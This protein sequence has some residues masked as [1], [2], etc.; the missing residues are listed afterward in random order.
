MNV[1][2]TEFRKAKIRF[3][4]KGKGR[5]IVLVHGFLGSLEVWNEFSE[6]LSKRFR[7]IAIDL[8]GHGKSPCIGYIHS[9]ELLAECIK[10]VVDHLKLKHCILIGHSMGGYAALSFAELFP[11]NVSGLCLFHST[12]LP[13][14]PVKKEGRKRAIEAVKNNHTQF[15]YE[16]IPQLFATENTTRLKNEIEFLQAIASEMNKQGIINA[17]EGMKDRAD[18]SKILKKAPFPV[19]FIA[20]KK[21]SR[22]LLEEIIPQIKLPKLAS[23]LVLENAGHMGFYEEKE[24]TLLAITKFAEKAFFKKATDSQIKKTL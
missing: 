23:A 15:T 4:D 14:T 1:N 8:P 9:M 6:K 2:Y 24:L 17:L 18:K 10:S 11:D 5:A 13:D 19:L 16:F 20:G 21:D 3:S 7:V 12:A 22:I